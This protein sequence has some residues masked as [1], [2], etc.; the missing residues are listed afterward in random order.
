MLITH[1]KKRGWQVH[2]HLESVTS[3]LVNMSSY[4]WREFKHEFGNNMS[5]E[6][7]SACPLVHVVPLVWEVAWIESVGS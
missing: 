2:E 1:V 4:N 7:R 5:V 3:A 6:T